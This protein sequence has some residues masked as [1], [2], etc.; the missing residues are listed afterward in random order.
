MPYHQYYPPKNAVRRPSNFN[1]SQLANS[2]SR[3]M[4][5]S[6]APQLS[7]FGSA[8]LTNA[9][10]RRING[11]NLLIHNDIQEATERLKNLHLDLNAERQTPL[12]H[13]E[14][15]PSSYLPVPPAAYVIKSRSR[16]E[17]PCVHPQGTRPKPAFVSTSVATIVPTYYTA[18]QSLDPSPPPEYPHDSVELQAA[19]PPLRLYGFD[20]Y[21]P[22]AYVR[23]EQGLQVVNHSL[24]SW[25]INPWRH[26]DHQY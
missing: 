12:Y 26:L 3:A 25:M 7:F 11:P 15:P 1:Y 23:I 8:R 4:N 18:P 16:S 9:G 2:V 13:S 19:L 6:Q 17:S 20:Q 22:H 14:P 24:E 10:L 5:T 21:P